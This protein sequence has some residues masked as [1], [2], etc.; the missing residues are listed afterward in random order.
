MKSKLSASLATWQPEKPYTLPSRRPQFQW[1]KF[2]ENPAIPT[3]PPHD[4]QPDLKGGTSINDLVAEWE[5]D[6]YAEDFVK[7]RVEDSQEIA[8]ERG[9][10]TLRSLR[11]KAGLSQVQLAKLVGTQQSAIARW[12]KGSDTN[13]L[14]RSSMR[15]L[16]R[17]LSVDMTMLDAALN[18]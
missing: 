17:A 2:P 16:A 14:A 13:N 5:R 10:D 6:G 3:V 18:D 15:S 1:G 12:E 8:A 11:L 9:R 7:L 4:P